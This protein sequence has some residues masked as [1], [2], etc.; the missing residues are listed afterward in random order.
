MSA[1]ALD[2]DTVRSR[3]SALRTPTAFFD[4]SGGTQVPD[5]VI[6]AIAGYLR[7]S[8][9]NLG[10]AFD[11]SR[12]S[13]AL[14]EQAH[15]TAAAFLGCDPAETIFGA[16]MTTLNFALTRTFGRT[17]HEGDEILVTKLDHDGNVAPWLELAH[18]L[19]LRVGFVEVADDTSLDYDDLERKLTDRTRVVAF[20]LASNAV[21]TLVDARRIAE[22]AHG[23]GALTWIDA[24]HYAPHGPIDVRDLLADVLLCS[25]YKF[26]GPHLG[27]ATVRAD[28]AARW[29]TYRVRPATHPFET[30]TLAHELLAGF[31]AAV[32]Y[33]DSIGWPAIHAHE[34]ALGQQFL[35]GLPDRCTLYGLPTMEGRVPTFA[36]NVD[37]LAPR[38]VA[39][40]LAAQGIAVWDGDYFAVEIMRRLGLGEA[41]AV[42]AGLVH[43]NTAAEVDRLL[44]ALGDL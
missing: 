17:L 23:A 27:L 36:F 28:L 4:G 7:E 12:R 19:G 24:V 41:G 38:D 21:G 6:D 31:I 32:E 43:Y 35:D 18:D 44:A 39:G 2:V 1:V 22:L 14:V 20:T 15:V 34:R 40:R 5:S 25:P 29:R 10:G 8:N 16:N 9:A 11:T 26:F 42:R 30:G 3:F 37:G 33:I 13:D